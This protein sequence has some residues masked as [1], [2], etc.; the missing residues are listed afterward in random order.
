MNSSKTV[1]SKTYK[2][3]LAVAALLSALFTLA[4]CK[5]LEYLTA[6][7]VTYQVQDYQSD[8]RTKEDMDVLVKRFNDV[9]PSKLSSVQF[10]E[11]EGLGVIEFSRGAPDVELVAF[12]SRHPGE[13][14]FRGTE[15][16][17]IWYSDKD[18]VEAASILAGDRLSVEVVFSDESYAKA[19]PRI[20]QSIGRYAYTML[21]DEILHKAMVQTE[22]GKKILMTSASDIEAQALAAMLDS[23]RMSSGYVLVKL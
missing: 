7:K 21:D 10:K 4:G 3:C 23:G 17:D 12:L 19:S 9:L 6:E 2:Q 14:V 1:Q 8:N 11:V 20:K 13:L 5:D 15:P 18:V 16:D 22:L